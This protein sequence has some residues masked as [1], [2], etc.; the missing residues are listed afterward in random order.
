MVIIIAGNVIEKVLFDNMPLNVLALK[1]K[2]RNGIFKVIR[3][4]LVLYRHGKEVCYR[5]ACVKTLWRKAVVIG[6]FK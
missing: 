5:S 4:H 6:E 1:S 2:V 3:S